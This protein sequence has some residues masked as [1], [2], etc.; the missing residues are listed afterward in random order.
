MSKKAIWTRRFGALAAGS[1]LTLGMVAL[2][3]GG[4]GAQP[5]NAAGATGT[6]G[7]NPYS[8]AYGHAYRHGAVPTR[9]QQAEMNTWAATHALTTTST[10]PETLS[11]G[12]GIGGVGVTSGI[13]QIYLVFWGSQWTTGS[14]DP[15]GAATY[16]QNLFKGLGTNNEG[17]SGTMTQYCDG[18][19]ATG[20]TT[21]PSGSS[22]VGY[23][24]GGG[25]V[26]GV[27]FDSANPA[28]S[29]ATSTQLAQEAVTASTKF[30]SKNAFRDAQFDI[31]SPSGTNPDNWLTGGFCAWHDYTGDNYGVSNPNLAFTNMPYVTD[32]GAS[33]GEN[34]VNSGSAGLLDGFSIVNG[35][36]Y[37]ETVTDQ[38][39]P[40]GW[41]N[42]Q[43]GT[44]NGQENGDE[45]A[46]IRSGTGAS[47]NVNLAT[48]PFA[49]QSTWSNDTNACAISH[50][51]VTGSTSGGGGGGANTVSVT[52]PPSVQ[53]TYRHSISPVS[54]TANDTGSGQTFTWSV[55]GLPPG[56]RTG[57]SS[58]TAI[59]TISGTPKSRGT[60]PVKVTATDGTGASGSESITWI[61]S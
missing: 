35:H 57:V 59:L 30:T 41:T 21:C 12:G 61:V 24:T 18:S 29:A 20:S 46:W 26:A 33:C 2:Q 36:E 27:W 49:M 11:Y 14:G 13:P 43:A 7:P 4:A 51:T 1:A 23:P 31:L 5:S 38:F 16:V 10:G 45:C 15:N 53:S 44:Y 58:S 37:A 56:L 28:P 3:S 22:H 50:P 6:S 17:W 40:G 47:A 52:G 9:E 19:V 42:H 34:F 48:G 55:S 25:V 32:V 39:P 8:P 54:Y 60:Y